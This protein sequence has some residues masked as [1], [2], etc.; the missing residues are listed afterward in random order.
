MIIGYRPTVNNC[1]QSARK[2]SLPPCF[3]YIV[4][5]MA[6]FKFWCVGANVG[7][8]ALALL[9]WAQSHCLLEVTKIRI[10]DMKVETKPFHA[11]AQ[12]I[13]NSIFCNEFPWQ[14][15]MTSFL[16]SWFHFHSDCCVKVISAI[17]CNNFL[18]YCN[19]TWKR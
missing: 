10:K 17:L 14:P 13:Q 6:M 12:R 8:I 18:V 1:H 4:L 3:Q 9:L 19:L 15:T 2:C 7:I 5:G 16:S 11:C